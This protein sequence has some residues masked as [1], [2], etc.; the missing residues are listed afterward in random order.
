MI[1]IPLPLMVTGSP[2]D[3]ML[4]SADKQNVKLQ[5]PLSPWK[6]VQVLSNMMQLLWVKLLDNSNPLGNLLP[7]WD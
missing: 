5:Q 2:S 3:D 7:V 1:E 4:T 6:Q